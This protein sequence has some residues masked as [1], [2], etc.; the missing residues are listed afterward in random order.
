MPDDPQ[1]ERGE[2]LMPIYVRIWFT[3]VIVCIDGLIV[4]MSLL[5]ENERAANWI[6]SVSAG[7]FAGS[8]A[9]IGLIAIWT[10]P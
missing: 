3:C 8:T 10:A 6:L 9:I 7:V 5:S 4:G 2:G 1:A